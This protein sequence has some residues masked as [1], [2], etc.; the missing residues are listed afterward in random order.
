M[1]N[2]EELKHSELVDQQDEDHENDNGEG[3]DLDME[4][5]GYTQDEFDDQP[6]E[7]Q[8][9]DLDQNEEYQQ[10]TGIHFYPQQN[11]MVNPA[12]GGAL[13]PVSANVL[14]GAGRKKFSQKDYS[15]DFDVRTRP[16]NFVKDREGLY[17]DAIKFK[18]A[19]NNLK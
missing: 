19:N 18:K 8:Q 17:E 9:Q 2:D 4:G 16:K 11:Q 6:D 5:E 7:Y 12:F 15:R 1:E 14:K 3:E 13:R 10:Q